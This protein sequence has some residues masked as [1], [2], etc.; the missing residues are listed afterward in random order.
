[1]SLRSAREH[2]R[3]ARR[4]EELPSIHAEFAAG[5]LSYTK[6]RAL[7]RVADKESEAD[8]LELA[9][10]ATA[11]Q[12][13]HLVRT[14]RRASAVQAGEVHRN[15]YVT[16]IWEPDGSLSLHAN[17]PAEDGATVIAA[18]EAAAER[19]RENAAE[20]PTDLPQTGEV[21]GSAEPRPAAEDFQM[22]TPLPEES[23]SA[24]P[25]WGPVSRAEALVA[26]ASD[27]M[28]TGGGSKPADRN[29]VVVH[30]DASELTADGE[31]RC[32]VREGAGLPAETARRIACDASVV[33]LLERDGEP[34]SVGRRSRSVPP[35][36]RRAVEARDQGCRF[37]GCH[38]KRYVDAHHIHHWAT[39]GETR[40]DNLLMLC[41]RHHRLVHEGG[42]SIERG[43][44]EGSGV[45]FKRPDGTRLDS[46][47]LPPPIASE[48][49]SIDAPGP[50]RIGSGERMDLDLAVLAMF[51][52]CE[53]RR[54]SRSELAALVPGV[55]PGL[56]SRGLRSSQR[57]QVDIDGA[58]RGKLDD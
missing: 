8:L 9:G 41:R 2:V 28:A 36:M 44:G 22:A 43:A 16:W 11:A 23:G 56:P 52:I 45:V 31:G 40:A 46:V 32:H 30:V 6:V 26:V 15:R 49:P 14:Y 1:M 55:A 13:D 20:P 19:I 25:P 47:P 50:L 27:S 51:Q 58:V 29:L 18:L 35:S 39:G 54:T 34:L 37:P 53:P 48:D 21:R 7:T 10:H 24:E 4:L 3:V 33:T 42:Y 12:L 57:S 38:H 5:R 17:L